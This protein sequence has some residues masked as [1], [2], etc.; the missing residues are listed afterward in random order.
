MRIQ[1]SNTTKYLT[2]VIGKS[3]LYVPYRD[4]CIAGLWQRFFNEVRAGS[5]LKVCST[6]LCSKSAVQCVLS[7]VVGYENSMPETV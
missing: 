7:C 2:W 6:C 4:V 3:C 1:N 5:S